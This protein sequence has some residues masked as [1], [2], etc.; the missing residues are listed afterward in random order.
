MTPLDSLLLAR[1]PSETCEILDSF[2]FSP[3]KIISE[4]AEKL[5]SAPPYLLYKLNSIGHTVTSLDL[6]N[7][8]V[9]KESLAQIARYFPNLIEVNATN[10]PLDDDC[11]LEFS[12]LKNLQKL[13][14]TGCT[15]LSNKGVENLREIENLQELTLA[16]NCQLSKNALPFLTAL[17]KLTHLTMIVCIGIKEHPPIDFSSLQNLETLDLSKNDW[18]TDE[19]ISSLSRLAK[20]KKLSLSHCNKL[21][22]RTI[23]HICSCKHLTSLDL[24]LQNDL[25]SDATLT[26]LSQALENLESLNVAHNHNLSKEGILSLKNLPKLKKVDL[27]N[28]AEALE[29]AVEELQRDLPT[30]NILTTL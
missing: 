16:A 30:V 23:S 3:Q 26:S 21:S 17:S 25:V 11:I 24:S 18:L 13:N 12:K 10:C 4:Y 27:F 29:T 14:L 22:E 8:K 28:C 1:L 9:T 6:S 5:E 19:D 7:L 15:N 2:R 20:L